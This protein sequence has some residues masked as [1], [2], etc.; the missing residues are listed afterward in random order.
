MGRNETYRLVRGLLPV[1]VEHTILNARPLVEAE[2]DEI[3]LSRT[4]F[5]GWFTN[6]PV[7]ELE[8]AKQRERK[9]RGFDPLD[10]E[11]VRE[12][13]GSSGIV[14]WEGESQFNPGKK[15][16]AVLTF[17]SANTKTGDMH[18]VWIMLTDMSPLKACQTGEDQAVCG[19]CEFRPSVKTGDPKD[20][21]A[22]CYVSTYR[23]GPMWRS[24]KSGSYPQYS[25]DPEFYDALL[26]GGLVRWGSYGEPV[27]IPLDLVKHIIGLSSAWTGYTH[28]WDQEFAAP[29]KN[30]FMASVQNEDMYYDAVSKGWRTFR[31]RGF[32]APLLPG[33]SI[34]PASIEFELSKGVDVEC[35]DCL[36]CGG[37]GGKGGGNIADI[38]HGTSRG[39][40]VPASAVPV[41]WKQSAKKWDPDSW[42]K[43]RDALQ[44]LDDLQ[45]GRLLQGPEQHTSFMRPIPEPD[46]SIRRR[47]KNLR[48]GLTKKRAKYARAYGK[49]EKIQQDLIQA[50]VDGDDELVAKLSAEA[51][52]LSK[53]ID[54]SQ[55]AIDGLTAKVDETNELWRE[56]FMQ[57]QEE[58]LRTS[59]SPQQV[60]RILTEADLRR[61]PAR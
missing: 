2:E 58:S 19:D 18:Q 44:K 11:S 39:R 34:C 46:F 8:E 24:Y 1:G 35:K 25:S 50:G 54:S 60:D 6:D 42:E 33:E 61:T 22:S 38:V 3:E 37:L 26:K 17:G 32:D 10:G 27:L 43:S 12:Q 47:I 16:V 45:G 5:N 20:D 41:A 31:V 52:K 36:I 57:S 29:F 53:A 4:G 59:L 30:Y 48:L 28:A 15:V 14:L 51:E 56:R 7:E 9:I 21:P 40:G 49:Y 55:R 23:M 13:A